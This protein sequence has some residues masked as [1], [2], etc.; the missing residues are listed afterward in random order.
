MSRGNS[1]V[2]SCSEV[3][4]DEASTRDRE[5][6]QEEEVSCTCKEPCPTHGPRKPKVIVVEKGRQ[7][8]DP[9]KSRRVRDAPTPERRLAL[10]KA[11]RARRRAGVRYRQGAR[12]YPD[13]T[14]DYVREVEYVWEEDPGE[15]TEDLVKDFIDNI[16][17]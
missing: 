12:T 13:G 14:T 15:S 3:S 8:R 6:R 4:G 9:S 1:P 11:K 7:P 2:S 16:L 5:V 10:Q 17:V